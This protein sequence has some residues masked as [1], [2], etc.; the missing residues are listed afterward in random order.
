M[1]LRDWEL[2]IVARLRNAIAE[3]QV[4]EES[5]E[6]EARLPRFDNT[7]VKPY[8]VLW[9]GQRVR[10]GGGHNALAGVRK[11]SH[12]AE[13]I[14]QLI[15]PTGA[16]NRELARLVS[17]S[18]LGYRPLGEGELMEDSAPTIRNPLDI[19][20]VSARNRTPLAYSGTVDL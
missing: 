14:A 19:S 4:F 9:W 6:E 8:V 7:M 2:D 11:S 20:G 18:L 3:D 13:F 10:G 1:D 5:V 17:G 12:V 16:M 15:A